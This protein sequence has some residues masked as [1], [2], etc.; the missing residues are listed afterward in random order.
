MLSWLYSHL[1]VQ[2]PREELAL[3]VGGWV[4]GVVVNFGLVQGLISF[5]LKE[6]FTSFGIF[7][8][9]NFNCDTVTVTL[10]VPAP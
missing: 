1:D 9:F 3:V 6:H 10:S 2:S 5:N 4:G 8:C 7:S